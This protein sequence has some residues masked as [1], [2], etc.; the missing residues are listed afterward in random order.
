MANRLFILPTS[1]VAARHPSWMLAMEELQLPW[2]QFIELVIGAIL[3]HVNQ[4][5]IEDIAVENLEYYSAA[6]CTNTV[7]DEFLTVDDVQY[8][9][10]FAIVADIVM[11]LTRMIYTYLPKVIAAHAP[12]GIPIGV[13]IDRL[14]GRDLSLEVQ[15]AVLSRNVG[16]NAP[17][18]HPGT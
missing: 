9:H 16:I 8:L 15:Y 2:E 17:T 11:D 3:D 13:R 5:G 6:E 12:I 1:E 14:I 7:L 4:G 10:Y 18:H